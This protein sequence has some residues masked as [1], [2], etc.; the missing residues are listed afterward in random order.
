M[1]VSFLLSDFQLHSTAHPVS[2]PQREHLP[3]Y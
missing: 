1:K 3:W 2:Q